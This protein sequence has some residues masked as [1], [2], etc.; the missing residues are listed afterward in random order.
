ML[1][2]ATSLWLFVNS[3]CESFSDMKCTDMFFLFLSF[4]L[5]PLKI[6]FPSPKVLSFDL[7]LFIEFF[8]FFMMILVSCLRTHQT[9]GLEIFLFFA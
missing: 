7:V 8:L 1:F 2:Q 6:V 9:L 4:F 5:H 3:R